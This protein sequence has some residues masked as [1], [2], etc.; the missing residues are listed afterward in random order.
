LLRRNEIPFETIDVTNDPETRASLVERANGRRT[1]PVIFC[2]DEVIG[3]Y[4]ELA[5]L[6]R[7]GEFFRRFPRAA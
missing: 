4:V 6:V 1:V 3:G 5:A 2:G 7:S